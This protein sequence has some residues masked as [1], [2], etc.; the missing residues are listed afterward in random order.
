VS[1]DLCAFPANGPRTVSEVHQLL[2]AEEQ[3]F[4]D[5]MNGTDDAIP[6]PEPDMARFLAELERRWP[7]LEDDPG[8]SPWSSWPL[9]LPMAGGG[10]SLNIRWSRAD[11]MY[12]AIVEIAAR[13]KVI[14]YDPQVPKVILPPG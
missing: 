14:I 9:W 3:R 7:S 11:E 6:L 8:G 13:S 2:D 4:I 1:F 12:P 10:T 5:G